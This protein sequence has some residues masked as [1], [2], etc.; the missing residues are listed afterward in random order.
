MANGR[1][2][3]LSKERITAAVPGM[4]SKWFEHVQEVIQR[5]KIQ[6]IDIWNMDEIGFQM[7]HHQKQNVVFDRR[8]GPPKAL[9]SATSAWVSSLECIPPTVAI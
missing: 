6:P 4:L 1:G 8:T 9:T 7:G 2:Q 5:Y 3:P